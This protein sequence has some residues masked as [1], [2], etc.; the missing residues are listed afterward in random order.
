MRSLVL[1]AGALPLMAHTISMSTGEL[2]VDGTRAHYEMRI[3]VYEVAH[4]QNAEPAFFANVRFGSDG[5]PAK[6]LSHACQTKGETFLCTA[7]YEFAKP[8]DRIQAEC[9]FARIT[10]PNHVSVL[11]ARMGEKTDQAVFDLT[12]DKAELRFNPPGKAEIAVQQ[13]GA[14]TLR[15]FSSA[16]GILFLF[17]LALAARSMRELAAVVLAF[18]SGEV[19]ACIVV[20]YWNPDLSMRFIEAAMALT[21]AYLAMEILFLPQA[22][23]RWL[24]CGILG[25]FHG[26]YFALFSRDA[27]YRAGLVL[28]GAISV[29]MILIAVCWAFVRKFPGTVRFASMLLM[30]IGMGWFGLRLFH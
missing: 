22:G 12:Y 21:V 13:I 29:E 20:A 23:T 19:A 24:I 25:L 27:G 15:V 4:V 1:L 16:A 10:V 26:F 30:T 6:L 3:P 7:E 17:G 28:A 11:K 9:T 2:T 14:G 5:T 18:A 8:P